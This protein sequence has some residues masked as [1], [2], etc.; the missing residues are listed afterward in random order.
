MHCCVDGLPIPML[1]TLPIQPH[2]LLA[3][4]KCPLKRNCP[5]WSVSYI[6]SIIAVVLLNILT[7]EGPQTPWARRWP[8]MQQLCSNQ[9]R[10]RKTAPPPP[11]EDA[12]RKPSYRRQTCRMQDA[13][14]AGRQGTVGFPTVSLAPT[15]DRSI[16]Y[17]TSGAMDLFGSLDQTLLLQAMR[18]Y[19]ER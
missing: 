18:R 16:M 10:P 3:V 19:L 15:R 12:K 7:T 1:P 2:S 14:S 9:D 17:V 8:I 13:V 4:A 11:L 6:T 5:E